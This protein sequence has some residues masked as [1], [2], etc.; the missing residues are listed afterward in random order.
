MRDAQSQRDAKKRWYE[1]NKEVYYERNKVKRLRGQ[2]Y[3]RSAK[4]DIPCMD[5]GIIYPPYVMDFDHRDPST[6]FK[7]VG[8]M[9]NYSLETIQKEI[10]KCDIVCA[11][12][13]R[14]RTHSEVV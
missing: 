12:C 5:C 10:D 4:T 7:D 9:T 3:V 11:N 6:K 1:N 13:H 8:R 2:E 14:I